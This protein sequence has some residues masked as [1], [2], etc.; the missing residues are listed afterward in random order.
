MPGK[1]L[2]V[3]NESLELAIDNSAVSLLEL[4]KK[5]QKV[6]FPEPLELTIE[7]SKLDDKY[8]DG[9]LVDVPAGYASEYKETDFIYVFEVQDAS[10]KLQKKI[11][12][13]LCTARDL[14]KSAGFKGKKD[15]CRSIH[16]ESACLYVG[17]SGKLRSR[18]RQHLGAGSEGIYAMHMH[19]WCAGIEA[20]IKIYCYRFDKQSG[21]IVQA[22]EDGLWDG[23]QP[24][25]GR[26]GER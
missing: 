26:K 12:D 9:I 8:I 23:F 19:R 5:M 22:L 10:L 15:I 20:T 14:Q 4:S 24:M 2:N 7:T 1:N 13:G 17:R 6:V 3:T 25:F 21:L 16:F 18:L 11:F